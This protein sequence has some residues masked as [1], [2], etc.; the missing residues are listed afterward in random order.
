MNTSVKELIRSRRSVR[1][2]SGTSLRPEDRQRI[3]AF[4]ESVDNP[5]GVP[6]EFRTLD[7][8]KYGLSSPVI[9]GA[10]TYVAAKAAR[11]PQFEIAC[12]YSFEKFCLFALSLGVGTV[13][14]AGTLSR[15]AF[16]KA[17]EVGDNEVMPVASPVGYPAK[18]QSVRERLM[19]KGI[20]ADERLAFE[21]LFFENTFARSLRPERA[22]VFQDALE[23]TR[24]APSAANR[25]PWRAVVCGDRVH[26]YEKK[27]K[28]MQNNPPGDIQK[29]DMGIALA[30]FD[31][32]LREAGIA[33]RFVS[34]DP[35]LET[36]EKTE[37]IVTIEAER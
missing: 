25:Q 3:A 9:V 1:T 5:F 33:A 4:L 23:M 13:M 6:V 17:M 21:T 10:D 29:V 35:G 8:E 24:L 2:F 32:T 30:H 37:Y 22:G 11:V 31:L 18:K 15:A 16:K 12:G 7:A 26:F 20:K 19:R 36:D 27:A 28:A 14:L 34:A